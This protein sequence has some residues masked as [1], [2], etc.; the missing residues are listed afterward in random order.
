[1][2]QSHSVDVSSQVRTVEKI[3]STTKRHLNRWVE[4]L[5]LNT[6]QGKVDWLIKEDRCE[7]SSVGQSSKKNFTDALSTF[8]D[9]GDA[10]FEMTLYREFRRDRQMLCPV[11]LHLRV[12]QLQ[13]DSWYI[14]GTVEG[15]RELK[16]EIFSHF[17]LQA[18]QGASVH[19]MQQVENQLLGD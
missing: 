12:E 7:A 15:N 8:I 5:V 11:I 19:R 10:R 18:V 9:V 17:K 4:W 16:D 14:Y 6:A 3:S 2:L 13:P 1:M